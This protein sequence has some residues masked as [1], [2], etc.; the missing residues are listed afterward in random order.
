MIEHESG[1]FDVTVMCEV[2]GVSTS[3]YYRSIGRGAS[4]RRLEQMRLMALIEMIHQQSWGTYGVPRMHAELGAMG[5]QISP[6]RVERLMRTMALQ[7]VMRGKKKRTTRRGR[8]A[9]VAPDRVDRDFSADSPNRLWV[10]DFTYV[11]TD[12]G[13]AYVAGVQD[14]FS[15]VIVGY[16]VTDRMTVDLVLDAFKS[17]LQRRRPGRGLVHHSDQGSQYTALRFSQALHDAGVAASMGSTGDA[18]DNAMA[19]SWIGTLKAE[20]LD[21]RHFAT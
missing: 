1:N 2:L 20:C 6:G 4:P 19:E 17:A 9:T 15:R 3:G 11:W 13:W 14:V 7:G 18:Y 10:A 21:G 16:N 12:E 5:I 8:D